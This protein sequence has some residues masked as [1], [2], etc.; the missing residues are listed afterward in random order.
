[1]ERKSD[2][3]K[4]LVSEGDYK[5]ALRIAKEFRLGI[6]KEDSDTMKRGYECMATSP[7]FYKSLGFDVDACVKAGIETLVRLYG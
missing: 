7:S 4:R 5:N 6:T 3:V 1:M 2:T